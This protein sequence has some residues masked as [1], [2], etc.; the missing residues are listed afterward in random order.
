MADILGPGD[1]FPDMSLDLVGGG[2]IDLPSGLDGNYAVILF[3]RVH[4]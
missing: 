2:T 3:Y 1:T 4:W